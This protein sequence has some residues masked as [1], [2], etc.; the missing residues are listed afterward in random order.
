MEAAINHERTRPVMLAL[1]LPQAVM[2][3]A[4]CSDCTGV[5]RT[6]KRAANLHQRP[7]PQSPAV[8]QAL[9]ANANHPGPIYGSPPG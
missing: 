5:V 7:S 6:G 4:I 2:A 3:S 8:P 9:A 1:R